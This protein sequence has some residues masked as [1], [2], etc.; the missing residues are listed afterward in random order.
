[1]D[2]MSTFNPLIPQKEKLLPDYEIMQQA[3]VH[4]R[5]INHNLRRKI[6]R[7][8]EEHDRLTV[9]DIYIRMRL[10]QSIASQHLAVLRRAG[11]VKAERDGKY[12][13]YSLDK[14]RLEEITQMVKEI[15]RVKL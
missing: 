8:L 5:A 14:K 1:M 2:H 12:I 9:T 6:L 10:E 3:F 13:Y 7:L 11:V 15:A 4:L